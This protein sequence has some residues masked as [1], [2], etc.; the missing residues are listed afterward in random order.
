MGDSKLKVKRD[1]KAI[2]Q[3]IGVE[4][5]AGRIED[6]EWGHASILFG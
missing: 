2:S 5:N 1:L 4:T 6:K 3:A